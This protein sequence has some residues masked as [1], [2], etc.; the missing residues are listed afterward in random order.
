MN[1]NDA[2]H[3]LILRGIDPDTVDTSNL[4]VNRSD[5]RGD[6]VNDD[7]PDPNNPEQLL[8]AW[9]LAGVTPPSANEI[10]LIETPLI[11][12]QV[13]DNVAEDGYIFTA[14]LIGGA[15]QVINWLLIDPNKDEHPASEAAVNG[16]GSWE[17]IAN[18]AGAYMMQVWNANFGYAELEVRT[19]E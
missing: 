14:S 13:F 5:G 6:R 1:S 2:K 10:A 11:D 4:V 16:S 18:Q 12:L 15:T 3:I 19:I 9:T 7:I 17:V 8:N